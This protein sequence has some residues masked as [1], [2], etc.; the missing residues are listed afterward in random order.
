MAIYPAFLL[1]FWGTV[2]SHTLAQDF[3]D[4][5]PGCSQAATLVEVAECLVQYSDPV[6]FNQNS[7]LEIVLCFQEE[8]VAPNS[9]RN[10]SG[11]AG[12]VFE[13]SQVCLE[14]YVDCLNET[15]TEALDDLPPCVETTVIA[16]G[17]CL[18]DNNETCAM[19]CLETAAEII[20]RD[21]SPY[22]DLTPL[23][24][25]NCEKVEENV[26]FPACKSFNCCPPCLDAFED[27]AECIVNDVL[28]LFPRGDDCV[29]EC[30]DAPGIN[31]RRALRQVPPNY[32]ADWQRILVNHD[33][34]TAE[35]LWEKCG[36]LT[37]GIVGAGQET[38]LPGATE[39]G[40]GNKDARD[41]LARSNFFDCLMQEFFGLYDSTGMETP[42]PT[43]SSASTHGSIGS[44]VF[45][46]LLATAVLLLGPN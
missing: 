19:P 34:T 31:G 11:W 5:L 18:L 32:G 38:P 15:V 20:N 30:Q 37:P 17:Q 10:A 41:L 4:S 39:L 12:Q 2:V 9:L 25:I 28:D 42:T 7:S 29:F 14:P 23:D 33:V 6:C 1:V 40:N 36:K 44:T 13:S 3:T 21:E 43:P 8:Y 46:I 26:V 24:V 35:D 27:V 22:D 45:A 16:L